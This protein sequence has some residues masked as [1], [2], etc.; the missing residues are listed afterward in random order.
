MWMKKTVNIRVLAQAGVCIALAQ[1]LSYIK[2]W[3]MPQGGSITAASMAPIL[4]FS[5]YNG[6]KN[7][8]LAAGIFGFLQFLLGGKMIHPLSIL[9]DYILG[10]GVLGI[11]GA[12]KKWPLP[13]VIG[14]LIACVGRFLCSFLSG[15]VIFGSY[16]PE[17][18]NPVWYS[19][20]YNMNYMLPESLVAI[21]VVALL[22]P[23]MG[24][25]LRK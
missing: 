4:L 13:A 12:F 14:S 18:M 2:I 10:F 7:G 21:V 20:I 22:Y 6:P 11:A 19:F 17:G 9:L 16:A 23:V 15:F 24:R 25:A 3:E 8:V 5:L 1:V